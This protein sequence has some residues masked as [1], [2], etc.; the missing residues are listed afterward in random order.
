MAGPQAHHLTARAGADCVRA[1]PLLDRSVPAEDARPGIEQRYGERERREVARGCRLFTVLAACLF[2]AFAVLD[3]VAQPQGLRALLAIRFVTTALFAGLLLLPKRLVARHPYATALFELEIAAASITAMC[4]VLD[5]YRSPYYAGVNLVVL[6]AGLLLA[7]GARW[8]A[9]AVAMIIGTWAAG[10]LVRAGFS[11]DRPDL[12][13]NNLA[14]LLG[15]GIISVASSRLG[16]RLRR[17]SFRQLREVSAAREDLKREG[18]IKSRF[19]ANVSHELRTPL[20]LILGPVE[21]LLSRETTSAE[22]RAELEVVERNARVLLSRVNDLLDAARLDAHATSLALQRVDLAALVRRV[23]SQ[24]EAAAAQRGD[25]LEVDVGPPLVAEVDPSHVERLVTNLLSNAFKFTPSPG[26][27]RCTVA[28]DATGNARI[29]VADSGKGIPL[30]LR[31]RIFERFFQVE[32]SETRVH[33]GTG[34]GLAIVREL[35]QLHGGSVRVDESALGGAAFEVALPLAAPAG[36][37]VAPEGAARVPQARAPADVLPVA[38]RPAPAADSK[39]APLILVVEDNPDMS[40]FLRRVLSARFSVEV[41][42]DGRAGLEE[43][44]RLRPDL[45]VTDVMMP[46]M[47]GTELVEE[48]RKIEALRET[49]IVVLTARADDS[50]RLELLR[51]GVQDMVLKPFVPD[52]FLARIANLVELSRSRE[53]LRTQLDAVHGDLETMARDVARRGRELRAVSRELEA[54]RDQAVRALRL[55][56]E[57]ISIA[58]HELRTPLTSLKLV[59]QLALRQ[60][61]QGEKAVV[62]ERLDAQVQ[63]LARLVEEMLDFSRVQSGR[64]EIDRAPADLAAIARSVVAEF[65][66]GSGGPGVPIRLDAAAAVEGEWD[67]FR[68]EQVVRNIVS[69]ALK[70]GARRPVEVSVSYQESD[71]VLAVK[72]QGIGIAPGE[73]QRIFGPFERAV[74]SREISGFGLGLYIARQIV[75]AHGGS[76]AVESAPGQGSTFTVR[77]PPRAP[78]REPAPGDSPEWVES[79]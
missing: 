47:S 42:S 74:P 3:V 50:L 21:S 1:G 24:F 73:Q 10:V 20:T 4:L 9:A 39:D 25:A 17:E 75:E 30:P 12:L 71:A 52:E 13:L 38:P 27:I 34:L 14:F 22:V 32:R 62:L 45:I 59:S 18:E 61:P 5:G 26:R 46:G 35:V 70:Y 23:A 43:A 56:E 33:G 54:A 40:A 55:R 37:A 51:N 44:R 16:D 29:V 63:R 78:Q 53:I 58:S 11:I 31:E 60:L 68:L 28:A 64:L 69:N 8:M 57:F 49:P 6:S 67:A 77:L 48:L 19:F 36:V 65:A 7:W 15:T 66:D 76:I 72:D 79:A 41:A 2:P